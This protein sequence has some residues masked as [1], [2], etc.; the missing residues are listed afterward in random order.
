[1]PV[2]P[3]AAPA[4]AWT[5]RPEVAQVADQVAEMS[6]LDREAESA[7]LDRA[8]AR[9]VQDQEAEGGARASEKERH[10]V[11]VEALK[12]AEPARTR[13]PLQTGD[14]D[15]WLV[16]CVHYIGSSRDEWRIALCKVRYWG[17]HI[18]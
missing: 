9:P 3:S 1:V 15:C 14:V 16:S 18:A 11:H 4:V 13:I 5:F 10:P 7:V 2:A 6:A 8:E 12:A 17:Q